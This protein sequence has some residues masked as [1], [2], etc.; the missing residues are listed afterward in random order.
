MDK[1]AISTVDQ[2]RVVRA[3]REMLLAIGEDPDREGLSK[4]PRRIAR[5]YA[6]L[7]SG[8]REDPKTVLQ[9]QFQE[10]HKEMVI[11][12][13]IPFYSLCEHH[14]LPFHGVAHIGYVPQGKVVGIS[15]IARVL[16]L[17]ARRLQMQERL[18]SQVADS[19]WNGLEADGVAVVIE[20]EH[21]CL[22]MRGVQKSG[23]KVVTSAIRGG[24]K[25]RAV[26]RSEF[27]SLLRSG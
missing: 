17:F 9:A 12:R 5:M 13:D 1:I 25:G 24:F 22:T 27:L 19:I 16:E 26:T 3:V 14:L 8:L 15:K 11:L 21:L 6:E 20:A 23:T 2:E 10:E 7:L 4:T 18:T